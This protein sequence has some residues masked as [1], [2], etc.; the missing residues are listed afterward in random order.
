[1]IASGPLP[2]QL[3]RMLD[4]ADFD[5]LRPHLIGSELVRE[6]VLGEAGAALQHV[7]FPH[8]GTISKTVGLSEGQPIEMA[9]LGRGSMVGGGVAL[10]DG[11]ATS[12]AVALITGTASMLGIAT[13]QTI[14]AS[15]DGRLREN[16][17]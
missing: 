4:A 10:A 11:I 8:A 1:M 14:A 9:M 13:F 15:H 2:N 5:L 16:L 7:Y 17:R 12:D 3:L 6:T